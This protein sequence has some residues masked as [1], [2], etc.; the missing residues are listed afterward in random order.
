MIKQIENDVIDILNT[1]LLTL[2]RL[3]SCRKLRNTL[4]KLGL[5]VMEQSEWGKGGNALEINQDKRIMSHKTTEYKRNI[6]RGDTIY[7]F[8]GYLL[9]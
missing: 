3:K 6:R 4:H 7:V 8:G 1:E 9:E 5:H 2:F